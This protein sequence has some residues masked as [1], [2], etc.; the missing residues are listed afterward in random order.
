MESRN[1]PSTSAAAIASCPMLVPIRTSRRCL[2]VIPSRSAFKPQTLDYIFDPAEL[3]G[4]I[5][6]CAPSIGS[7][8][9]RFVTF[10]QHHIGAQQSLPA[11]NVISILLQ[12]IRETDNHAADHFAS[13]LF[14]HGTRGGNV[15]ATWPWGR[16]Y[17]LVISYARK[18]VAHHRKPRRIS[19]RLVDH[20]APDRGRPRAVAVLLGGHAYVKLCLGLTGVER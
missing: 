9:V 17:W 14:A 20:I 5:G 16:R 11:I 6:E 8:C 7:S 19:R 4:I 1:A 2:R 12:A 3:I 10:P 15:F 18:C 13:I